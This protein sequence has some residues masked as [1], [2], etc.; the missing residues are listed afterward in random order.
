LSTLNL[1]TVPIGNLD[2]IS[3]RARQKIA[4]SSYILAED[5]RVFYKLLNLLS[6]SSDSK[7][8]IS[9]HDHSDEKK[10]EQVLS[11]LDGGSD[12]ALVSDA[13]SPIISD[14]AYP[15]IQA[16]LER[17]HELSTCPGVSSVI[18]ALELSGLPVTPFTFSGF[19][20]R[21]SDKQAS[22]ISKIKSNGGTY[23]IFE[24]PHRIKQSVALLA[25]EITDARFAVCREMTKMYES[26]YRF[27]S[28]E[29]LTAINEIVIKGEFV[30][31]IYVQEKTSRG[32]LQNEK[33]VALAQQVLD[34]RGGSKQLSKLLGEILNESP[35]KIYSQLI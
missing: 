18:V 9:F 24:S 29:H 34:G 11:I 20:P 35:K 21:E 19:F 17:G 7:K 23:V 26:V 13:G 5:S 32:G 16:T 27:H 33:L 6:I 25:N 12:L 22:L 14:P 1:V 30:I 3:P 15:L 8:V 10:L 4:D 28:S 31:V 2:D